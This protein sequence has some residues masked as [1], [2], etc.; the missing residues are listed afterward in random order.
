[1]TDLPD[2]ARK[3]LRE[4]GATDHPQPAVNAVIELSTLYLWCLTTIG[5]DP[6]RLATELASAGRIQ[7]ARMVNALNDARTAIRVHLSTLGTVLTEDDK[8]RATFYDALEPLGRAGELLE[9]VSEQLDPDG[10]ANH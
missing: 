9:S 10:I 1:M 2:F 8:I 6:D 5:E 7:Q 4:L 3:I